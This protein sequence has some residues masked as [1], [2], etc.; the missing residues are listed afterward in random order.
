MV[1]RTEGARF[2]GD[3][4]GSWWPSPPALTPKLTVIGTSLPYPSK[5][6]EIKKSLP[7]PRNDLDFHLQWSGSFPPSSRPLIKPSTPKASWVLAPSPPDLPRARLSAVRAFLPSL[8]FF[9][10]QF[11]E[12]FLWTGTRVTPTA[13]WS[14]PPPHLTG[15]G[16]VQST[17]NINMNKK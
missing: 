7:S 3:G 14:L 13:P 17:R 12:E 4:G 16:K 8:P 5:R 2:T 6:G 10:H 1:A 11:K 9:C 15:A